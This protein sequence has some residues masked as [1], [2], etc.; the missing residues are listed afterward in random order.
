MKKVLLLLLISFSATI[1]A[2][3][4][5]IG[6][7]KPAKDYTWCILYKLNGL[8]QEFVANADIK[9]GQFS[10]SIPS[11]FS[12]G[13]YRI[14]YDNE[15]NKFIDFIYNN[16][17]VT[18]EFHPD[19]P[20]ELVT[21]SKSKENILM[22]KY[23][24]I[25]TP[26]QI[27]LENTQVAYFKSTSKKLDQE[28]EKK[29]K[30][31]LKILNKTQ[32]KFE[33]DAKGLFAHHFIVANNRFYSEKM[34]K[35]IPQ[36]LSQLK[37]HYFDYIDFNNQELARS[38][39]LI[40]SVI[41]FVIDLTISDDQETTLSLQKEAIEMALEHIKDEKIKLGIV[42]SLLFSFASSENINL[43][44]YIFKKQYNKFPNI[45][46][47]ASFKK[48]IGDKLKVTIGNTARN[49]VWEEDGKTKSL[50]DLKG[51]DL[52]LVVFWS[53]TCGHCLI[54]MPQLKKYLD[55]SPMNIKV[56]AIGLENEDSI[57]KWKD[58]TQFYENFIH[59]LALDDKQLQYAT[60]YNV[61]E[62][63]NFFLLNSNKQIVAKPYDVKAFKALFETVEK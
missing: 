44:N 31:N 62:T 11:D 54:E 16:E 30:K 8:N 49:I 32:C 23:N 41:E 22:E 4:T 25:I 61:T 59:V 20:N 21:Y 50:H 37:A 17:N 14:L 43:V 58:E 34:V 27:E 13:M 55:A 26:L 15:N 29:Y 46:N 53:S 42:K 63:P 56:V 5:V 9:N 52:Y 51:S 28:L 18:F 35:D 12:K 33:Q 3:H 60:N 39:I 10:L 48:I 19:H 57:T 24:D 1:F 7:L 6:T 2:Q 36:Y 40:N 47:D 38:S 45:E